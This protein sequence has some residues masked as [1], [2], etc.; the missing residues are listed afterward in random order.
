MKDRVEQTTYGAQNGNTCTLILR[1]WVG[2]HYLA[3]KWEKY[4]L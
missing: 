1:T 3:P 2:E 4:K